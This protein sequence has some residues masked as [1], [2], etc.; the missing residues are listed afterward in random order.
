MSNWPQYPQQTPYP[1]PYG[2]PAWGMNPATIAV[3]HSRLGITSI[4]LAILAGLTLVGLLAT[5]MLL[6][7]NHH[8]QELAD[9]SPEMIGL[10][11]GVMFALLIALVGG[12]LALIGL[13][14]T[15]RKRMTAVIG[16]IFNSLIVLAVV[17]LM[18]LGATA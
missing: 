11:V 3:K 14:M 15:D 7:M 1:P 10:G 2:V 17:G 9:D 6:A 12:I 4:I 18:I 13:F 16:M 8:G 5:A